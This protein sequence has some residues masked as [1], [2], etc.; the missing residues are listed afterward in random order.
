MRIGIFGGTFNP[1]HVGHL[2]LAQEALV[3]LKLDRVV[4]VPSYNP[5]HKDVE[6]TS[7]AKDRLAMVRLAVEGNDRFEVS[8]FELEKK[9]VVYSI[10]TLRYSEDYFGRDA[11]LF[12]IAGSDSLPELSSW[13]DVDEIFKASQFVVANRPGYPVKDVPE[14]V[15]VL[16]I[17]P[18]DV[19]SKDI[20]K[21]VKENRSIRYLVDEK[22]REYITKRQLYKK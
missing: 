4:F 18:V 12:F 14:N 3:G 5:P 7:S 10:D 19:S 13:K 16:P 20:R 2:I 8:T 22:V 15:Q 6:G 17:P 1:I 11:E 21:R 9:A